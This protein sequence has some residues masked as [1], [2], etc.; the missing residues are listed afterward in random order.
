MVDLFDGHNWIVIK[1]TRFCA[2]NCVLRRNNIFHRKPN[3]IQ[4]IDFLGYKDVNSCFF[5]V[6]DILFQY[7]IS[8][9]EQEE[10]YKYSLVIY[11]IL[12]WF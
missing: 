3:F 6:N 2:I 4:R 9:R 8:F 7:I 12:F 10:S 1:P 11:F 5:I